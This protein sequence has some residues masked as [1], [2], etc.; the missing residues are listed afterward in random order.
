MIFF[1]AIRYD[2]VPSQ[3]I[4]HMHSILP[5]ECKHIREHVYHTACVKPKAI[6]SVTLVD[7][8]KL[9]R[10]FYVISNT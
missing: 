5:D 1:E 2:R 8:S 4:P 3:C 10:K 6:L 7:I 9:L